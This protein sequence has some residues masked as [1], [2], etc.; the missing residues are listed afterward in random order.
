MLELNM[1]QRWLGSLVLRALDSW[2]IDREFDHEFHSRPVHCRVTLVN[3]AFNPSGVGKW[4]PAYWMGKTGRVH[5]C[6]VAG[7]TVWSHMAGDAP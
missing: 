7:N 2:S 4:V 6:R 5:L 1:K 3:S